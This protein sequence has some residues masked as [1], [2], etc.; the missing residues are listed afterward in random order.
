M[1]PA[2]APNP[3]AATVNNKLIM[4]TEIKI[5]L[6]QESSNKA[7]GNC[8]EN[9]IR[10]LLTLHQYDIRGNINFS[11]MEIDLV[12]EHK[13]TKETLYVEC[14]AKEKVT[15]DELS[16]F[17][18]NVSF[19][20]VNKG[21]FFRTQELE[22][23]AGALLKEIRERPEYANLI[24][25]EPNDIVKMLSDGKMIFEPGA[26]LQSFIISKR[27]LAITY[28]G[29]YFIYL[30]NES[31]ALPTKFILVDAKQN[32]RKVSE[33]FVALLK[34]RVDEINNL[35]LLTNLTTYKKPDQTVK[36]ESNIETISEVQESENWYDYLPASADKKHFVGRDEIRTKI[37]TYFKQIREGKTHKRIFYLNGKSGWGKSSLV[38]ELKDRCH[39]KHFK[40]KF[41]SIAIDT[42]SATSD[43]FVALSFKKLIT[44]AIDRNFISKDLFSRGSLLFPVFQVQNLCFS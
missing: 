21:Y 24:F 37:L 2:Q 27:I 26:S 32:E 1:R 40:R 38:L 13:H 12:A 5:V 43:N 39:N 19:K 16:K 23:Q 4:K 14:K 9:L 28:F 22:S 35:E 10:N 34:L 31:N 33:E 11:G 20:K 7:K 36:I 15:S 29:D 41:L 3:L 17:A 44:S 30:V 42:R 25:F 18:F 8:F 6:E